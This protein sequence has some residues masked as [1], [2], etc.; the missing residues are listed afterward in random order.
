MNFKNIPIKMN[1]CR[2]IAEDDS[3]TEN[4]LKY[5]AKVEQNTENPN[6]IDIIDGMPSIKRENGRFFCGEC[7]IKFPECILKFCIKCGA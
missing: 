2:I 1:C 4:D 5:D 6:E 7:G 3:L